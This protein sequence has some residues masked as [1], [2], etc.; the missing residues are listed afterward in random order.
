MSEPYTGLLAHLL[1]VQTGIMGRMLDA[2]VAAFHVPM[3][4][5]FAMAALPVVR[6]RHSDPMTD[7]ERAKASYELAD[8]TLRERAK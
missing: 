1:E 2:A 7:A 4:D 6:S 5:R 8:A 3:R